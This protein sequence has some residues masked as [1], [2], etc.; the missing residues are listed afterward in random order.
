MNNITRFP[1]TPEQKAEEIAMWRYVIGEVSTRT[2]LSPEEVLHMDRD[3]FDAIVDQIRD[4]NLQAQRDSV[5]QVIGMRRMLELW[6]TSGTPKSLMVFEAIEQGYFTE[7]D[8]HDAHHVT[9]A[10]IDAEIARGAA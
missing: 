6:E 4:E 3:K 2:G 10:D 1:P 7:Q 5:K 8:V 9:E